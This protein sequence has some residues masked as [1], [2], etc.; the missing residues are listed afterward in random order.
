M[1]PRILAFRFRLCA[2]VL[3]LLISPT[4][5]AQ[6]GSRGGA[7]SGS[8]VGHFGGSRGIGVTGGSRG[9]SARSYSITSRSFGFGQG[10]RVA[11]RRPFFPHGGAI[12]FFGLGF[13]PDFLGW[14]YASPYYAPYPYSLL[15]PAV[16]ANQ[17]VP[18]NTDQFEGPQ[19]ESYWL[20][21]LKDDTVILATD[22]WQ[23]GS[24]LYYITRM[25]NT[26]SVDLSQ[27]D[28]NLTRELNRG[29]GREF[30]LPHTKPEY[31]PQRRD[32]FGR[33]Y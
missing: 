28:L 25:G 33:P 14:D 26:G 4:I 5:Y 22:Y 29:L 1:L 8:S 32:E 27:L 13:M 24:T 23:E 15:D 18:W 19:V 12:G 11:R 7:K 16:E 9:G 31:Q 20:I 10:A 6:R 21:S 2:V 3:A 30:Q 17:E